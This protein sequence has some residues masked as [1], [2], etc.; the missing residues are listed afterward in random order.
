MNL[1]FCLF[2][3]DKRTFKCIVCK[4]GKKKRETWIAIQ[5]E[6]EINERNRTRIKEECAD[7]S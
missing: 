6:N 1:C 7:F 5:K 3:K 2:L 4:Y